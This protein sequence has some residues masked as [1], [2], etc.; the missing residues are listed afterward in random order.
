M[1]E[2]KYKLDGIYN[3]LMETYSDTPFM[4]ALIAGSLATI[5]LAIN[6]TS[7]VVASTLISPIGTF[8]I[9]ANLLH[10]L[11][12]HNYNFKGRNQSP[13]YIPL[14]LVVITTLVISYLIGKAMIYFNNPFT[15]EPLNKDW[16]T[17]EM[18]L[19]SEPINAIYFVPIA[20][21]CGLILPLLIVNN[22]ISGF[23]GIGIACS[24]LPPIAN[25]GLSLNFKYNPL[26]HPPAMKSYKRRAVFS[27]F[28]IFAINVIL[29][30]LP[31]R[32]LIKSILKKDN[33]FE[34]IESIFNF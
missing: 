26:V 33:I 34:K 12:K 32:L 20:L 2:L 3:T 9:Q 29:L 6:S 1:S 28:A 21:L 8:I 23:V 31:S 4:S 18:R 15:E 24:M 16:P 10:F 14:L 22:N 25:I 5:G 27:G 19:C 30:L 7:T 11:K 17:H 13:W